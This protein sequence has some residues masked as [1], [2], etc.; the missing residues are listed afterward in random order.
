MLRLANM[1]I[2]VRFAC[3]GLRVLLAAACSLGIWYSFEFARAD[4][5]F[6]QDTEAS[7]LAAIKAVPDEPEYYMRLSQFD[8]ND[9][10]ELLLHALSLNH[11][12]AQA[13]IEL[14][15]QYEADGELGQAEKHLLSAFA[16]DDTYL[17]RWSLANYY[18][19]RGDMPKFWRWVHEA[20]QMPN[21]E[22][23]ALFELSWRV[24][25]DPKIISAAI[26]NDNPELLRRYVDFL[27]GKNQ[28]IAAAD[29][30]QRLI[31]FGSSETDR[32][33]LFDVLNRLVAAN[34]AKE[35]Q[36]LW[37][38]L[39]AKQWV[40]SDAGE[41]NNGEF[42]REPLPVR[43]DWSLPEYTG[44]H[45]WPGASGLE[46]EFTGSEPEECTI[47]EQTLM[48]SPGK[49]ILSYWYQT[50]EIATAT[51]IRWQVVD[52]TQ[53]NVLSESTDLSSNTI[54]QGRLEFVVTEGDPLLRIR[55]LYKRALGTPRIAGQLMLKSVRIQPESQ[56]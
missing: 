11:Y 17:P 10:R 24:T 38:R 18:L 39:N 40:V 13:E 41:P 25:Q 31:Q 51:G 32:P 16:V 19:R 21:D 35:A 55:L 49:Y 3:V 44:L 33:A 12:N 6:K 53:E 52:G 8:R 30:A 26:V 50:A 20:A 54:T 47:A 36:V 2:L 4:Y 56:Q 28:P 43:F 1:S 46:S 5:L 48:L 42:A 27:I 23:D 7:V 9:T 37:Q 22:M 45:S 14:G 34:D 15:L 29:V